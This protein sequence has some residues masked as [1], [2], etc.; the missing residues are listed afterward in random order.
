M[1]RRMKDVSFYS[2]ISAPYHL[3]LTYDLTVLL[4]MTVVC[5]FVLLER[6]EEPAVA[7]EDTSSRRN[8]RHRVADDVSPAE[9]LRQKI[10]F[11]Q[12]QNLYEYLCTLTSYVLCLRH[13]LRWGFNT[14]KKKK[15][16][17]TCI[18]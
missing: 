12:R 18:Q 5:L 8:R 17:I 2:L 11:L 1:F 16:L 6:N 14:G 10:V 9:V 13:V 15:K 3:I 7:E 4:Y